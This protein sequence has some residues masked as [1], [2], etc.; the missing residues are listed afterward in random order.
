MTPLPTLDDIL[1][2][3]EDGSRGFTLEVDCHIPEHLHDKFRDLPIFPEKIKIDESMI[4]ERTRVI[5]TAKFGEVGRFS[6]E[7]LAPNLLPKRNYICHVSALKTYI[8][9]GGVVDRVHRAVA[10]N[11]S[12]WLAPYIEVT[13]STYFISLKYRF[14]SCLMYSGGKKLSN[15]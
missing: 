8:E 7:R 12:K 3:D 10:F 14:F 15:I 1:S 5:R 9:L 11:Q 2:H 13:T 6:E 4:S